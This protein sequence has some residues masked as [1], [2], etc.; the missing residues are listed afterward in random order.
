MNRNQKWRE[1]NCGDCNEI[2]MW[3]VS[4][5]SGNTYKAE[6]A[7][8]IGD[9][10]GSK[11]WYPSHRCVPNPEKV[12]AAKAHM[13]SIVRQ[14]QVE[15]E[16]FKGVVVEV[17]KGR[18]VPVG[19]KG[20]VA[21]MSDIVYDRQ[22]IARDGRIGIKVDGEMVFVSIRNVEVCKPSEVA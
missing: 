7:V 5:K 22:G 10:G 17:V 18:K 2:V 16:M 9:M 4:K 13:E 8:W 21:W 19:V 15:G 14:K 6:K 12:A 11:S 1:F 20:V 3:A